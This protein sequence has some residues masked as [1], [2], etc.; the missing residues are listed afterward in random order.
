[1]PPEHSS[2][3]LTPNHA[4]ESTLVAYAA[5]KQQW[6]VG[7]RIIPFIGIKSA[8]QYGLCGNTSRRMR[9][10]KMRLYS[11]RFPYFTVPLWLP[12]PLTCL[13]EKGM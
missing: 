1:M 3:V 10:G 11:D 8:I 9:F 12:N 5:I 2:V 4:I 7:N 6:T 13:R